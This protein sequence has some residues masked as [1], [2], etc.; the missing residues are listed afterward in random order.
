MDDFS[1]LVKQI[2]ARTRELRE[3]RGWSQETLA[4]RADLHPTYIGQLE[5]NERK[6]PSLETI[7]KIAK[8]LD[9][10]LSQLI[11]EEEAPPLE[12]TKLRERER[13][14][15]E[16]DDDALKWLESLI[17]QMKNLR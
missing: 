8:G 3:E 17:R 14:F 2:S 11:G 12:E 13:F 6:S 9:L 7:Y 4:G 5:R 15:E 10:T 16:L 1:T